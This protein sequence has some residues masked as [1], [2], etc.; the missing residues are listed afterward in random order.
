MIVL[1]LIK[2]TV[3]ATWALREIQVLIRLGCEIHVALPNKEGLYQDYKKVGAHVHVL[4]VDIASFIK[5][6]LG[7][8]K[9]SSC[10][11]KLVSEI[12]PDIIHSHF[13]GTTYFMRLALVGIPVK[14]IF[15]VPGPLHL[16]KTITRKVDISLANK[17]DYWIPTCH[18]SKKYYLQEGIAENRLTTIFYGS[19]V[20]VFD[21]NQPQGRLRSEL[22][23][24]DDTKII[25][26][27][28]FVYPPKKWL[29]Q[30]RGLKGHEDLID[31]MSIVIKQR[32]D[33]ACVIVGGAWG[34]SEDYYK[35]VVEYGKNNL[36][37]K[38]Y[39]LGTRTDV[40]SL[41]PDFDIAVHPSLSENLGGAAESL[42]MGVPT[43]ATD[44]GGFPD[45]VKE[46]KTGWLVPPSDPE[47]LAQ[48]ILTVLDDPKNAKKVAN[49][50]KQE[51][52]RELDVNH[53]AAQ[54][55]DFYKYIMS[56]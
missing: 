12:N 44:I 45:I 53:T 17:Y 26:M 42:L 52:L 21:H 27:V 47:I 56:I 7:F 28:A 6:P 1:H 32:N 2:T 48:K 29:G 3:G 9:A 54:V 4:N 38:V 19:D 43:I 16:E 11:R 37:D 50:G 49:F 14:R 24:L 41:Y 15:Q 31:A 18:L 46:D 25:G 51:M 22:D 33:V 40:P 36:R 8:V 34:D 20:S 35:H 10:L 30:N 39:F 13:V 5:S 23:I 55:F